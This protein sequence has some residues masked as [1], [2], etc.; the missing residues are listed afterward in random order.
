MKYV[1][2]FEKSENHPIVSI[3]PLLVSGDIKIEH[4]FPQFDPERFG[5]VI[6]PEA[7]I[8]NLEIIEYKKDKKGEPV[9]EAS[10][11]EIEKTISSKF[12]SSFDSN[13]LIFGQT[14]DKL[15]SVVDLRGKPTAGRLLDPKRGIIDIKEKSGFFTVRC[16]IRIGDRP[17]VLSR[18]QNWEW[19]KTGDKITSLRLKDASAAKPRS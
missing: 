8:H 19:V 11:E 6:A 15:I 7:V 13:L 3:E 4:H 17:V 5:F 18:R 12:D 2:I 14:I 10:F 1:V 16:S 9:F